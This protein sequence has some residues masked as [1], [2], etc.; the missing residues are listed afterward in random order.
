MITSPCL[1]GFL[2]FLHLRLGQT[3]ISY[4]V[5]FWQDCFPRH[6][7]HFYQETQMPGYISFC[8][9]KLDEEI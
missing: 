6:I 7:V 2:Y 9:L 8:D 1:N 3:Y 4:Y 5:V